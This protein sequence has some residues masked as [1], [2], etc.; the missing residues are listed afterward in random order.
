MKWVIALRG[1]VEAI[2]KEKGK[3]W[4]V[5]GEQDSGTKISGQTVT[6]HIYFWVPGYRPSVVVAQLGIFVGPDCID[7]RSSRDISF[8]RPLGLPPGSQIGEK[9][10]GSGVFFTMKPPR[11]GRFQWQMASRQLL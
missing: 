6:S 8:S 9:G 11:L 2:Y 4:M 5:K 10:P 3:I 1:I 7:W